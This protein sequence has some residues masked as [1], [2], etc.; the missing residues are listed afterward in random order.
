MRWMHRGSE[1]VDRH[2][3]RRELSFSLVGQTVG[4]WIDIDERLP[5]WVQ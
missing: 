5:K 3:T 1:E 2:E 4:W